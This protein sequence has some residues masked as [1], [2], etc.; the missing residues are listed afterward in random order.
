[1]RL[2]S[3]S[4]AQST[5]LGKAIGPLRKSP[6]AAV[7]ELSKAVVK[8]WKSIVDAEKEKSGGA[9]AEAP[10]EDGE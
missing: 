6:D 4:C 8:K 7:A 5:K 10:R 3:N 1:M 9:K 2:T